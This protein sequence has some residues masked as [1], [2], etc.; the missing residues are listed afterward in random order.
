M[1]D[2]ARIKIEESAERD[3]AMNLIDR[4]PPE[5]R[6]LIH[7]YDLYDV[8]EIAGLVG[9]GDVSGLKSALER[10]RQMLQ[11]QTIENASRAA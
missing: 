9:L 10:N 3:R 2:E 4:A 5:I 11:E 6:A 1:D 7:E 8:I